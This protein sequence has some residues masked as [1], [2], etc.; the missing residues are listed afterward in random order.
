MD[1]E[2]VVLDASVVLKWFHAE[3]GSASAIG[4]QDAVNEGRLA[5]IVPDLLFYEVA[6]ALVRG[7]NKRVDEVT[8]ATHL[9]HD[10]AWEVVA[11]SRTLIDDAV[12]MAAHRPGLTVYDA[13]YVALALQRN[14]ELIT[15]DV[16][17]HRLVGTP[18][19]RLL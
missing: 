6:N 9:L 11:P 5:S 1:V 4:L 19:T 10:M 7:V 8:A 18:V 16:K 3:E 12:A 2:R 17:L 13:V 15:A 14:A